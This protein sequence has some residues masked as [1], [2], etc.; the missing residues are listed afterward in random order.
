MTRSFADSIV[1]HG[2][3]GF[4]VAKDDKGVLAP[5]SQGCYY[6]E[7]LPY[8]CLLIRIC[9]QLLYGCL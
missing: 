8:D 7:R 2:G 3:L 5:L 4:Q 1:L 9:R 6:I